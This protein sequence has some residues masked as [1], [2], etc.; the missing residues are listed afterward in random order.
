MYNQYI[1]RGSVYVPAADE[2]AARNRQPEP[3]PIG[4]RQAQSREQ[5]VAPRPV[6]PPN[7][8]GE[9]KENAGLAGILKAFGIEDLDTGDILLL[10][11]ML[12]LM[13]EGDNLELVITLG[14]ML[15]LG[16][17]EKN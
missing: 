15:I 8:G 11:L 5:P 6:S 14:L 7:R 1:P 13:V 3:E 16:S 10:V 12:L 2:R 17:E 4:Y 9:E